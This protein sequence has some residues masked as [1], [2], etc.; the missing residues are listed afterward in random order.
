M[1]IDAIVINASP[2]I[3]LFRSGQADLLPRLFNRI[4]VPNGVWEEVTGEKQDVAA[5]GLPTQPWLIRQP[6]VASQ[7]VMDWGLGK[8]ETAV[9]SYA[10][11]YPPLRAVIDDMDARRCAQV[12]GI[13]MLGTGGVLLLAKRRRLLTSV[14]DGLFKLRD[15][16]LWLS[17]DV[18][19]MIK[20]QAGE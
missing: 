16:G 17:D 2:L 6:V 1:L 12:L 20:T 18:V 5:L 14:A 13:P 3:T 4:V 7:R 11:A 15:A 9:L 19:R 10:L 8:G